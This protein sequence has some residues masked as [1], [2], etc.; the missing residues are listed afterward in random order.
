M[1]GIALVRINANLLQI[2]FNLVVNNCRLSEL[3]HFIARFK[4]SC[5]AYWH[6]TLSADKYLF[7]EDT[8]K[9]VEK[10]FVVIKCRHNKKG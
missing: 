5:F 7:F 10:L 4:L 2:F 6:S 8:D 3:E 1:Y 9:F